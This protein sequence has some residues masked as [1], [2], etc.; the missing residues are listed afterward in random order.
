MRRPRRRPPRSA[1]PAARCS[2]RVILPSIL[3]SVLAGAGLAFARAVGEF[4][5]VVLISGNLPFKTEVASSWIYGL[6][7]SDDLRGG[8]RRLRRARRDLAARAPRHRLGPPPLRRLGDGVKGSRWRL[9]LRFTVLGYLA[10]LVVLPV[11][12][13]F[14]RAFQHGLGTAWDAITAPDAL[15]ALVAHAA[16]GRH[17]RAAQH[18]LRR[19]RLAHPRPPPLPGRL[20][21]RCAGRHPARHLPRR[22]RPRRSSSSTARPA[23]SATG[24]P[25][26]ASRSSSRCPASSWPRRPCRCPTS[27]AR[28]CRCCRRSAPS[29]SRRPAPSAPDRSRCSAASRC[30]TSGGAWPTASRSPPPA[31]W[32]SSARWPS[33]RAPSPARPQTLTLFISD[34]IDNLDPQSAYVG[35]VAL[36]LSALIVLTVLTVTDRNRDAWHVKAAA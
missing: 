19:R 24:W 29:R 20:A 26:T 16:R 18:G 33:S 4:G 8:Q 13:V 25:P 36:C 7:Q 6:I 23:G 22:H 5:S 1:P 34:S 10:L 32:A 21:A 28:S 27:S 12:T 17:R 2:C 30:P 3:P 31:C 9:P 15:H 14:Y 11:S 35:A